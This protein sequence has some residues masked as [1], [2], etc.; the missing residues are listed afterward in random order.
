MLFTSSS[1]TISQ[2]ALDRVRGRFE[3]HGY[4]NDRLHR[5][6]S[7]LAPIS[8]ATQPAQGGKSRRVGRCM[9]W[10]HGGRP[11]FTLFEELHAKGQEMARTVAGLQSFRR[12]SS[13]YRHTRRH[14]RRSRP[15]L[16]C[17]MGS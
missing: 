13:G 4:R 3:R 2:R 15:N 9:S 6:A 8:P 12:S 10:T 16:H 7:H 14:R 17:S 5:G 11:S 1:I